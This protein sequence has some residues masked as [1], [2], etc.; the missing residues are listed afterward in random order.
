MDWWWSALA[1]VTSLALAAALRRTLDVAPLQRMNHRGNPVPTAGGIIAVFAFLIVSCLFVSAHPQRVPAAGM[2]AVAGFAAVGLFD[3][4]VGTHSARGLRGHV[5]AALRGQLTSGATKLLVGLAIAGAVAPFYASGGWRRLLVVVVIAGAANV[6][7][8]FD[9]A[10]GRAT[11]VAGL[12]LV[13]LA[14]VAGAKQAI[15][16]APAWF[17]AAALGLL[18][19]ELRERLM[20]GDAGANALGAVVGVAAVRA[21][22]NSTTSLVIAAGIAVAINIA[23]E[24]VSFSALI[25]RTPPLRVLDR[26]GRKK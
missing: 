7:N 5:T 23:G 16:G 2:I 9:L 19:A 12:V 1:L 22:A 10:P 14:L 8:L 26:L 24:L 20:L 6:G 17:F 21:C 13:A 11:K 25:D 15:N 18:P 3:D 4:V